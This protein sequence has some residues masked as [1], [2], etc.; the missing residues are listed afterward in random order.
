MTTKETTIP[1]FMSLDSNQYNVIMSIMRESLPDMT[2]VDISVIT[3]LASHAI[4][5]NKTIASHLVMSLPDLIKTFYPQYKYE[6]HHLIEIAVGKVAE[7]I[8][9]LLINTINQYM[10]PLP[11][12]VNNV[13]LTQQALQVF[14]IC[15]V[16][17]KTWQWQYSTSDQ[18]H[19]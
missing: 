11:A 9:P 19:Q 7:V 6:Q 13:I 14:M 16:E 8:Y 3:M 15:A 2:D 4:T 10:L 5:V 18:P 1:L 17:E 12:R